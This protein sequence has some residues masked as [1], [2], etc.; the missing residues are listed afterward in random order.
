MRLDEHPFH[1]LGV[2]PRSTKR[3]ILERAQAA[4]AGTPVLSAKL[5]G[6]H[7]QL[8]HPTKRL[9][10]EVSW[11]PGV[12]PSRTRQ[13]IDTINRDFSLPVK[14]DEKLAGVD[15]VGRFN[16]LGY[17]LGAHGDISPAKWGLALHHLSRCAQSVDAEE[18]VETLNADRSAA[19]FPLITDVALVQAAVIRH[20]EN[21]AAFLADRLTLC[22][23]HAEILGPIVERETDSG[24]RQAS[25]FMNR[26]VDRYQVQV[27]PILDKYGEDI[28]IRCEALLCAAQRS[29][30]GGGEIDAAIKGIEDRLLAW[31]AIAQP[32]QLL[33]KSRGLKDA[34]SIEVAGHVRSTAVRLANEFG[35]HK[36]A[37]QMTSL[38]C[39]VFGEVPAVAEIAQQDSETLDEI[40]SAKEASRK[41]E[42]QYR[43]EIELDILIGKD[44][45]QINHEF[46][47]HKG[48]RLGLDEVTSLRWGIFK[49]YTNGI[50]TRREFTIWVAPAD[51]SRTIVIECVRFLE[52][53]QTVL[54][55]YVAIL[56]KLWKAAGF[57]ILLDIASRLMRGETVLFGE[58]AVTKSGIWLP[59]R[60]WFSSERYFAQ[61]EELS[62]ATQ[63]G[64]LWIGS[65]RESKASVS[66]AL[67]DV[68]NAVVLERLLHILWKDGN[69]A[70]LRAGTLF[71]DDREEASAAGDSGDSDV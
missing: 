53:E 58:A 36:Q 50:R 32:I 45:L 27:Q 44:R 25:D 51:R 47:A 48:R 7:L 40:L 55:R 28:A 29:Q 22:P 31:D 24:D 52:S 46:I 4:G 21:A 66:L 56:E 71:Q 38:L 26:F 59:K 62:K 39:D 70:K 43:K 63:G 42:E 5:A 54:E 69:Y 23:K 60:K 57:R 68:D 41:R 13:I 11:F 1:A 17:W 61:W 16:A 2:N 3:E 49:S 9:D 10:A 37:Q 18:L 19:G 15:F 12:S 20:V 6:Y 33:M 14:F 65:T 67:R 30:A 8:T 35:L 64:A 34:H